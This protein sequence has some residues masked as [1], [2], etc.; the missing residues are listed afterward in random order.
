MNNILGLIDGLEAAILDSKKIPFTDKFIIE[1][2]IILHLIDKLRL[3][4]KDNTII[5]QTI[6]IDAKETS[7]ESA[8]KQKAFNETDLQHLK[9]EAESY[10]KDVL[11]HLQLTIT[12]LQQKLGHLEK[13]LENGRE[14]LN[15]LSKTNEPS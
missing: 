8:F 15:S 14:R 9:K 12:K 2:K 13:T 5:L 10:A 1:E 6:D 4:A 3:A 7:S 11:G